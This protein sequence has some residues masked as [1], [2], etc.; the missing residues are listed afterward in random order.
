M[1]KAPSS[2]EEAGLTAIAK[3]IQDLDDLARLL[4]KGLSRTKPWQQNIAA[5]LTDADRLL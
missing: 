5:H 1:I 2:C 3:S 4:A